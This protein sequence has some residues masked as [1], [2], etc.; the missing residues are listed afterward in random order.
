L[1]EIGSKN[2]QPG[3]K[4]AGLESKEK[5]LQKKWILEQ[6]DQNPKNWKKLWN[7]RASIFRRKESLSKLLKSLCDD[8]VIK[9]IEISHKNK[10]YQLSTDFET[11]RKS[12]GAHK[13]AQQNHSKLIKEIDNIPQNSNPNDIIT[14]LSVNFF[15]KILSIF[16]GLEYH[17]RTHQKFSHHTEAMVLDLINQLSELIVKFGKRFP[18]ETDDSIVLI[19]YLIFGDMLAIQKIIN[20]QQPIPYSEVLKQKL[21]KGK[22][23]VEKIGFTSIYR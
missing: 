13:Q 2:T 19:T 8:G 4:S 3:R 12:F 10:S 23:V 18:N 17:A 6:L 20:T 7:N 16:D 1:V 14:S 5:K 11:L 22:K 21:E 9:K 15:Q